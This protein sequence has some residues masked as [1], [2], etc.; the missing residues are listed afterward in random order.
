MASIVLRPATRQEGPVVVEVE[1]LVRVQGHVI[2]GLRHVEDHLPTR[3]GH[4][5]PA[6]DG[7]RPQVVV[8]AGSVEIIEDIEYGSAIIDMAVS[9]AEQS[10]QRV[11]SGIQRGHPNEELCGV[12]PRLSDPVW[13]WGSIHDQ[14]DVSSIRSHPVADGHHDAGHHICLC[15]G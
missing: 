11:R 4:G 9:L 3:E 1:G 13:Q 8:H 7:A 12:R 5:S 2:V 15:L 10:G 14:L 6:L